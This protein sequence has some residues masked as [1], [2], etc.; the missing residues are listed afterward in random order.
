MQAFIV[1]VVTCVMGILALVVMAFCFGWLVVAELFRI[2][3]SRLSARLRRCPAL[4]SGGF[5][6]ERRIRHR[7]KHACPKALKAFQEGLR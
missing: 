1:F 3:C 6:C 4:E 7:G 2:V 5:R